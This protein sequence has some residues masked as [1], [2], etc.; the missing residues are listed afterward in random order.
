MRTGEPLPAV[1]D[2]L[3]ALATGL[4]RWDNAQ[5]LVTLDAE[6]ARLLG[7]PAEAVTLT[8]AAVRARFHPADW[9]EVAGVVQ[10][11]VAEHTLAEVRL[12]VMDEHGRVLRT[13]RS[14]SKPTIDPET[15][16][17][18]LFGT[19]QEVT[20]PSPGT[21]ART[22]VTGDW[23]RS[24]EAFLLDA[25]RALAE[26]RSTAE[27]LRVAAGLSMPGFSPDGLAVFGAEGDRLTVVGHHG[28]QPGDEGPFTHMSLATDYPAAEVVRTGRAVYL[29]SPR[30][31][32]SAIPSPGRWPGTS[33]GS[34]GPFCR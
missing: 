8:E 3:A 11:A 7:L 20:E 12:R 34:P 25:G 4:W 14:R 13:A 33:A 2:V 10:L 16:E 5:G 15:G 26:A 6:A 28:Q 31:T 27:V 24:R 1:G 18:H 23:R 19:L 17:F 9:N 32:R 29:S 22:P 21:A 30:T